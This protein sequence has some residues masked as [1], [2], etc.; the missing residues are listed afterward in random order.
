MKK[1]PPPPNQAGHD[2]GGRSLLQ[3]AEIMVLAQQKS[4]DETACNFL[5][6]ILPELGYYVA[7]IITSEGR[8]QNR[9]AKTIPEL[10]R[11]MKEADEAGHTAYH[12]CAT[13]KEARYDRKET[14]H[15][16]RRFGRT[17]L[18]AVWA[19][20]LWADID[21]GP[22]KPYSD[23]QDAG[24][25]V[26]EFCRTAGLPLPLF[27][28]SGLGLHIYWPL[29]QSVD[30]ATW[31]RYAH[32]LKALFERHGLQADPT[33]T[34]NIVAV[35]RTPGTHHRKS[36]IREVLCSSFVGPF[37][38]EV[39]KSLPD[40]V[41][42][43][44]RWSRSTHA[45]KLL[46][47]EVPAYL[48]VLPRKNLAQIA[49]KTLDSLFEPASGAIIAEYCAQLREFRDK[50][51]LI[52]EPQWYAGLGVLAHC[53][54]GDQ[55]GHDWSRGDPRYTERETQERLDRARQFGPTTCKRF[56]NLNPAGCRRCLWSR[57]I[58]SPIVLGRSSNAHGR[59]R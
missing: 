35:L 38:I 47:G 4:R 58:N 10:W 52:P 24:K 13:F 41:S 2:R 12:A 53:T 48:A 34:A 29:Q 14:P 54:D 21:A 40:Y 39:F 1:E 51:G 8:K 37:P 20:S 32:G 15:S 19:K 3:S 28:L 43:S 5:R 50:R 36:G 31:E 23:S 17:K 22:G 18:N 9:F 27:V 26:H 42:S 33:S 59:R 16:T 45:R 44:P 30:R 49:I 6:L 46:F 7:L 11:T 57:K 56:R 25:A 55:L